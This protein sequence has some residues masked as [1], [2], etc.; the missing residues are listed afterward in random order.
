MCP[1]LDGWSSH[2]HHYL[3]NK[4][5][6]GTINSGGSLLKQ[7]HMR[8]LSDFDSAFCSNMAAMFITGRT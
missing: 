3:P 8:Q 4:I 2:N 7:L 6:P 5:A 1:A